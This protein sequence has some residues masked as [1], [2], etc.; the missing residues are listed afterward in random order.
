MGED[1]AFGALTPV[2]QPPLTRHH[3]TQA[4]PPPS[5]PA[6]REDGDDA[7]LGVSVQLDEAVVEDERRVAKDEVHRAANVAVAHELATV[8]G[9][10]HVLPCQQSGGEG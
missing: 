5:I 2:T 7:P 9:V 6:R 3:L 10:E 8:V 4:E 1:A